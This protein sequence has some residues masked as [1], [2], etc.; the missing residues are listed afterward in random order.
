MGLGAKG[1]KALGV[2]GGSVHP[3]T[4]T[5]CHSR[6]VISREAALLA[7]LADMAVAE[8]AAKARFLQCP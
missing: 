7:R 5:V 2:A 3:L 6:C 4:T 8:P 1:V